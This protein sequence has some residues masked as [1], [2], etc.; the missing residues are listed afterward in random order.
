MTGL[1]TVH[2]V[3]YSKV[4]HVR[5][6]TQGDVIRA[7]AKEIPRIFQLL[8]AGEGEARRPDDQ[9]N[10]VD[11]SSLRGTGIIHK[12]KGYLVWIIVTILSIF[13]SFS[14]DTNLPKL[15]IICQQ[16][17]KFVRN[18]CGICLSRRRPMNVKSE[19]LT[20][21]HLSL[22]QFF[23]FELNSFSRNRI[24]IYLH[25][26]YRSAFSIPISDVAIKFTKNMWIITIHWLHVNYIMILIALGKCYY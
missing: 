21:S 19:L 16:L 25:F 3:N 15:V 14:Q 20:F 17:V 5:S 13:S 4:F 8:Y 23:L 6:V 2:F 22:N 18:H 24:N 26:F 12:G 11:M 1:I 10:Q 9:Q 7:D